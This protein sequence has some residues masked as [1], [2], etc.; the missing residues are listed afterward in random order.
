MPSSA[1]TR[2]RLLLVCLL[3]LLTTPIHAANKDRVGYPVADFTLADTAGK[4]HSLKEY[5]DRKAV[6]VVFLGTQCPIN[7]AFLPRLAELHKTYSGKGV[8]FLAVNANH[9]D[10]AE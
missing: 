2:S 10:T 9:Q 1:P 4:N 6:V 5:R 8:S 3:A 7:N